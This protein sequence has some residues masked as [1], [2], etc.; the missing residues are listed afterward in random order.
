MTKEL[1]AV[2]KHTVAAEREPY[3]RVEFCQAYEHEHEARRHVQGNAGGGWRWFYLAMRSVDLTMRSVDTVKEAT[4]LPL[5]SPPPVDHCAACP[6]MRL[7]TMRNRCLRSSALPDW[8]V[9]PPTRA[10]QLNYGPQRVAH[11]KRQQFDV[12]K[13]ALTRRQTRA[14]L[15]HMMATM[16]HMI[17]EDVG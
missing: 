11:W 12:L 5:A 8:Y 9:T 13:V 10:D 1:F 2:Y 6:N 15:Q 3:L 17:M 14:T 16:L 7:C 4:G